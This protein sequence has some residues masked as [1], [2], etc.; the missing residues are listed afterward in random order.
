[1]IIT[2][3]FIPEN[4][5][6][7]K[8]LQMMAVTMQDAGMDVEFLDERPGVKVLGSGTAVCTLPPQLT[9]TES[10]RKRRSSQEVAEAAQGEDRL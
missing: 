10:R 8:V 9:L 4:K 3:R 5:K 1:M 7:R 2:T 6:E